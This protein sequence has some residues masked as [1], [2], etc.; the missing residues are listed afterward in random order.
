MS[1]QYVLDGGEGIG[2]VVVLGT[3]DVMESPLHTFFDNCDQLLDDQAFLNGSTGFL[4]A[5]PVLVDPGLDL[6]LLIDAN[7]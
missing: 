3:E 2:H 7:R 1:R 5:S 6:C 4:I